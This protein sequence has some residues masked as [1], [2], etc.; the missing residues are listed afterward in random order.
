MIKCVA[1]FVSD[2]L[3]GAVGAGHDKNIGR[4]GFE[5]KMMQRSIGQHDTEFVV[6]RCQLRAELFLPERERWGEPLM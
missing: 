3:A 5:Q 6:F 1:V 2:R 4:S